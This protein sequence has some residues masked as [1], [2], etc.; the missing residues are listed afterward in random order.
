MQMPFLASGTLRTSARD[1]IPRHQSNSFE[2][3]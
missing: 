3:Y 1:L 2:K